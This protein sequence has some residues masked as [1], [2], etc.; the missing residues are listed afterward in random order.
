MAI[1]HCIGRSLE[2]ELP[3]MACA[4]GCGEIRDGEG[5]DLS[6]GL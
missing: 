3:W 2:M 6:T 1:H 5:D 4:L